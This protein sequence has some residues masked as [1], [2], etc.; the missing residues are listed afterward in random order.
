MSITVKNLSFTYSRKTPYE[1]AALKDVNLVVN[2]GDF[3]GIIGHTG[4]GKSTFL[5]HVNGLIRVEEGEIEV[6]DIRMTNK[7]RPKVDLKRLRSE[8]GMVFQYPEYQLFEESVE[9][10]IAFGAK[11]LGMAKE[12]ISDAVKEAMEMVGL[13]YETYR[14]RSPFDLSGGEKRRVAIAGVIVMKPKILILDEPTA[15]LDPE[16]KNSIL[17]LITRLKENFCP[18]IIV[19][20]HDVDEITR[21]AT[22]IVV[23]DSGKIAYDIPM[24]E[25]FEEED[26]LKKMGLEIPLAVRVR[27]R[28]RERGIDLGKDVVNVETLIGA[29]LKKYALKKSKTN[30]NSG[31]SNGV[32]CGEVQER[33]YV[34][35]DNRVCIDAGFEGEDGI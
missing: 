6:F 2:D 12:K 18:T 21:Y 29:A 17:T 1:K 5:Q 15:G 26:E 14:K 13:D 9:K 10:D 19:V 27:N 11:N 25:L 8:V 31:G 34:E 28:L 4:S 32:I 22:R 7:R 30:G 24:S 35:S 16:G 20:S 33:V 23:F 3:V